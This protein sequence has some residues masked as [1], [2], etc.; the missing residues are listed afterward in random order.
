MCKG[1][2]CLWVDEQAIHTYEKEGYGF[3]GK[4]QMSYCPPEWIADKPEG[5]ILLLDDYNRADQRYLQATMELID[6]GEYIS[7]KL[8]KNWHIILTNNPS[9]GDYLVN[10]VDNAQ[11]T[12]Y[13][14]ITM[15]FNVKEWATWA[16]G[17]G[18]DGRCINFLL[19]N[20]ELI[21]KNV[22]PRSMVTFFNAI[23]SIPDFASKEG[24]SMIQMMGEGSVGEAATGMF[25]TFINNKLDKLVTP[26]F[27]MTSSSEALKKELVA[28]IGKTNLKSYRADIASTLCARV[29]NY[30]INYAKNNTIT[31][32]HLD[33]IEE[34]AIEEY[35]GPDL[36]YHMVKTLFASGMKFKN[37]AARNKLTKHVIG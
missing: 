16:E 4:K 25:V 15:I 8:P 9:D 27:I 24:L 5:G 22:N 14:N 32:D 37:L 12:R 21:N 10:E 3:T 28:I 18:I 26:E 35:F 11:K 33:R 31:K 34:L 29:I 6:R 17:E 20:P 36:S 19:M 7:W 2:E 30:M 23:S 13:I 1:E